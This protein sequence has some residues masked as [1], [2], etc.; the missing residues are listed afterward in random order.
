VL[1]GRA[2]WPIA[3]AV[4]AA[5]VLV[6]II[7]TGAVSGGSDPAGTGTAG[8]VPTTYP[9][10]VSVSARSGQ[11]T[12]PRGFLGLSFEFQ[13]VRTYTGTDPAAV[14]PV[15]VQLIR[16][17]SPGQAPVLRIGGNSTDD[18]YPAGPGVTPPPYVAYELTPS[19]MATTAALQ[20]ALG[21]RMILGLNLADNDPAL[22]AAEVKDYERAFGPGAIEA[23]EIGNEPNVYGKIVE[24]HTAAGAPYRARPKTFSYSDY[25]PQFGAIAAKAPGFTLAGPAL[26]TGPTAAQGS[27]IGS[28]SN[29]LRRQPRLRIMTIHRY[30]LRNCFVPAS[31]PQY[32]TIAHLLAPYSTDGLA[33]SARPWVA[34]AHAQHRQLRIDELNSVACR[35]KAGVSDAF[36]SALWVL[37]A[38]FTLAAEGV[39]GVNVHTLPHSA[40]QLWSFSHAG[41]RW[42][43]KVTPVYYG[44]QLFAQAAPPGSRLLQVSR[45]GAAPGLSIWAT[46]ARDRTV[47]VALID[48][49]TTGSETVTLRAPAGSAGTATIERLTAPSV[50]ST[51]SV[52]LGGRSYGAHTHTGRLAP[53]Q[54]QTV[55]SVGGRYVFSISPGS[56][57]LVTFAPAH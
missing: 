50:A 14:N 8:A 17:L 20:K 1:R 29:L 5:G 27:W 30:P 54:V 56:A 43:A 37:D 18:S 38:M 23:F 6:A 24:L 39:D 16:N 45:Q 49:S 36:A 57:E 32:P 15:L 3:G 44:L 28:V 35:G 48:K 31:S 41:G 22:D 53:P 19:W 7:L 10:T 55:M 11:A 47:R 52:S 40:Y 51:G 21:A 4:A 34:I 42:S 13:A 2:I 33:A 26:A 25:V 46:R 9:I 12:I